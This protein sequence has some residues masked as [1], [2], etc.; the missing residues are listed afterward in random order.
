ML[1][2]KVAEGG[3]EEHRR[4]PPGKERLLVEGMARSPHQLDFLGEALV[5]VAKPS[6]RLGAVEPFDGAPFVLLVAVARLV[7]NEAVAR[8][9]I[10]APEGTARSDGPRHGCTLNG[11]H[12][13]D[14]VDQFHRITDFPI[15]LVDEREYRRVPHPADFQQPNGARLHPLGAVNDHERGIHR[16]EGAVGVFG[17]VLVAR[18][19]E[20]IH[21]VRAIVKLHHR[22]GDRDAPLLLHLHPV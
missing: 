14:L 16:R 13:L 9:Q 22:R 5:F 10:H 7:A 18:R 1:D 2:A 3:A 12:I 6:A 4:A 15:Q 19:V 21:D 20:Q 11:E 8:Q 17:E